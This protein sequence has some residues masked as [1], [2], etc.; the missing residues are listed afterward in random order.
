MRSLKYALVGLGLTLAYMS[1]V[2]PAS[3][4]I[5]IDGT[6]SSGEWAGATTA[7]IQRGGTAY[8]KADT[9]YV[10]AA[11]DITGWTSAMGPASQGNL[12]GFGVWKANNGFGTSDGVEFQQAQTAASWGSTPLNPL[13]PSGTMNGLA[14]RYLINTVAQ[15]SIPLDLLA[16][17][18]FATGNRVWEVRMPISGM[19][20]S[21][22]GSI[23][24]IGS[25]NYNGFV[26][27]YPATAPTGFPDTYVQ[28]PIEAA[29]VPE[30]GTF[31]IAAIGLA[32]MVMAAR[33]KLGD[34]PRVSSKR[35]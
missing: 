13:P 8:F 27:W 26:N 31:T 19:N 29:P 25:I 17:D 23:W 16:A 7:A 1:P 30:P 18:S 5:V 15:G 3:A 2:R 33:K 20:V 14:S 28:I 21:V 9:N 10:Y 24:A 34:S 35:Q 6:I 11:F 12:L 22:G 4:G 32:G